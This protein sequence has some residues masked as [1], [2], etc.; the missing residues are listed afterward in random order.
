MESSTF[1]W[2]E[3]ISSRL[4][5]PTTAPDDRMAH[6]ADYG[7]RRAR[8][9]PLG[10]GPGTR[11]RGLSLRGCPRFRP[12]SPR[13]RRA[14]TGRPLPDVAPLP[15]VLTPN[16]AG[17]LLT[18]APDYLRLLHAWL[19]RD[20]LRDRA[21]SAPVAAGDGIGW[22]LGWGLDLSTEPP[23]FWHWGEGVGFRAF[24]LADPVA[25][26]GIVVLTNADGGLAIA[27]AVVESASG[28][29][30]PAFDFVL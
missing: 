3:E 18:T 1:L 16:A 23:R 22:G 9:L 8:A 6:F 12:R 10:P 26:E 29:T 2:R 15:I 27:R 25:G 4:A 13:S 14:E 24:A 17:S 28:E 30:Q 20:D 5:R 19:R 7:E 11:P 21:F